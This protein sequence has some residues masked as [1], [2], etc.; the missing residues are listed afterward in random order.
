M[1]AAESLR[2]NTSSATSHISRVD[3][4]GS[5]F[6]LSHNGAT[7]A[8]LGDESAF[9]PS[10][11][12]VHTH[13]SD[14]HP[15]GQPA[16][17][18]KQADAKSAE[19]TRY[20]ATSSAHSACV[21][22]ELGPT[23]EPFQSPET[24]PTSLV[25]E[26]SE[27]P[28]PPTI[29]PYSLGVEWEY[30]LRTAVDATLR[31]YAPRITQERL[32]KLNPLRCELDDLFPLLQHVRELG[33]PCLPGLPTDTLITLV[34]SADSDRSPGGFT[35]SLPYPGVAGHTCDSHGSVLLLGD[36][37][38]RVYTE[39]CPQ[40]HR[41]EATPLTNYFRS[42]DWDGD[43]W[44]PAHFEAVTSPGAELS[45]LTEL[46]GRHLEKNFPDEW[47]AFNRGEFA[48][49]PIT[50]LVGSS[51]ADAC[52]GGHDGNYIIRPLRVVMPYYEQ[53]VEDMSSLLACCQRVLVIGFGTAQHWHLPPS[54]ND[55]AH[56]VTGLF[57]KHGIPLWDGMSHYLSIANYRTRIGRYGRVADWFAHYE[58]QG[59]WTLSHHFERT[60]QECLQWSG[61]NLPLLHPASLDAYLHHVQANHPIVV[62]G[63]AKEH[64]VDANVS[65]C[66]GEENSA[67]AGANEDHVVDPMQVSS[68]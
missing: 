28:P 10:Q 34:E 67:L 35:G 51:L 65:A 11:F 54:F 25:D 4:C 58:E 49:F 59:R 43:Q 44:P 13:S 16:E 7:G 21:G 2:D 66:A 15:R 42:R 1:L 60:L 18:G 17:T 46:L 48:D 20:K 45:T 56:Y 26:K 38:W 5:A 37:C 31:L 33:Y 39:T 53:A 14:V 47:N 64:D 63:T 29:S 55:H 30:V 19:T 50:V 9:E 6:E 40:S 57:A 22:E 61:Y 27:K 68:P 8:V 3:K 23:T 12:E 41:A 24:I 52:A 32:A 62:D 36:T